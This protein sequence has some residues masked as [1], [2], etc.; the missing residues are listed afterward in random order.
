MIAPSRLLLAACILA[1]LCAAPPGY[2]AKPGAEAPVVQREYGEC[3]G[4]AN[5]ALKTDREIDHDILATRSDDWQ[6]A[7]TLGVETRMMRAADREH[8]E[9]VVARCMRKKGYRWVPRSPLG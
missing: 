5:E 3:I 4:E 9:E 8:A 7:G 6:R 2:W 1:P